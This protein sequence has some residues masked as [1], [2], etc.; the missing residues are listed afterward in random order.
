MPIELPAWINYFARIGQVAKGV[1]FISIGLLS[2]HA[3]WLGQGEASGS[4]GAMRSVAAQPFGQAVLLVLVGGLICYVLWLLLEAVADANSKGRDARGLLLR[5]RSLGVA[6]IYSGL[7]AAALKT[8]LGAAST[9]NENSAAQDWTRYALQAPL[10]GWVVL[11]IGLGVIASGLMMIYR[12]AQR[13]F[14]E[15]LK[16]SELSG[17]TR[18]WVSRICVFGLSARGIVFVMV[19]FFLIQA[20]LQSNAGKARG[21][22]G[23]LDALRAQ[24]YGIVLFVL[25]ATG[26]T[27]YGCYCCLRACYGRWGER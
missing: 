19:G 26:L 3:A 21:L 5:A 10:G 8:V 24:P 18:R 1:I 13:K 22:G 11:V 16:L 9:G 14:E 7:T 15:K 27:A 6:V 2:A 12:A 20:G 4:R 17:M 25:V 23:A